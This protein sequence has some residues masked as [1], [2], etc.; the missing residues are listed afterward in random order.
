MKCINFFIFLI[1]LPFLT[2]HISASSYTSHGQTGLINL[3]SAEIQKEQ[4]IFFTFNKGAYYRLGTLTVTPFE[5]ME[6]SYFYYR[7]DD[8]LWGTTKGLFLDKGFNVKFSYKPKSIVLPRFAIGLDDFA[9]TGQF[10][11]EYI[12]TTY[13]FNNIKL[14]TGIGWGKFVGNDGIKN[15]LSLLDNRFNTRLVSSDNFDTGGNLSYD[16]WFRGDAVLFSGIEIQSK[17]FKNVRYKLETNPFDYLKYGCCGD[18]LSDNSLNLRKKQSDL[19]FGISYKFNKFG[20]LDFNYTQGNS[21][22]IVFSVGFSGKKPI[23]KKN[24][25]KPII[26][27]TRHDKKEKNEF[28][29]DLLE[30]LNNNKLFLQSAS[31]EKNKLSITI[32]SSDH[33]NPIIYSS[34]A[35][36]ISKEVS[37]FNKLNLDIIEVGHVNRGATINSISYK[38]NDLSLRQRAPNVLIKKNTLIADPKT[39][40]YLIH[41]FTPRVNFPIFFNTFAPDFRTHIGS[42]EKFIYYGIGLKS[43]SEIQINRNLVINLTAGKSFENNFD[44][45]DSIPNSALEKVR[46]EVVDYLQQSSDDFYIS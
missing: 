9:G 15:P 45:K 38:V 11:K 6:A 23:R 46:T 12:A 16:L 17:Y 25:F 43:I 3:P 19:N 44:E 4:S 10:T 27:N 40:D 36:F 20:N 14:T 39:K 31:L 42:P 28:Y 8:L 30:N 21:W 1:I 7:P 35:A 22:N 37:K 18:G 26:K 29:F 33:F 5:W 41:D 24:E 32:D 34:R 13:N 2:T